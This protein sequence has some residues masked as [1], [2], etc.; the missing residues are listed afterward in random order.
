MTVPSL[1]SEKPWLAHYEKNV[2]PTIR[3]RDMCIPEFLANSVRDFPDRTALNFQGYR[4]TF[5]QLDDMVKRLA[6]FLNT[7]GIKKGDRVAVLLPN[8]IQCVAAYYAILETGAVVVMNNPLYT[9]REL[10]HQFNDSGAKLLITLDL[11]AD[12]MIDLREETD[13]ETIVYTS[14]GDYLPFPKS[15]LFPL[16]AKKKR[17]AATV[18]QAENV[19]IW[20]E[21]IKSHAPARPDVDMNVSDIAMLQYTGGTTGASKG[22]VLT[23]KNIS[24]QIQQAQSWFPGFRKGEHKVLGALPFFHIFGLTVNM[25][26]GVFM[27]WENILVPKPQPENLLETIRKFRPTFAAFVPTM[28]IGMLNSRRISRTDLTCIEGCFSGSAPLPVEIINEFEDKTG[29]VIVEG[30]GLT[31]ASPVT[32]LNPFSKERRKV[33]SVGIPISDTESRI[34]DLNIGKTDV[35][36]GTPGELLVRGP[37]VMKA[38]WNNPGETSAA[39]DDGWLHTGDIAKMDKDGYFYIVDRL[40]DMIISGG[41]NVY[42]REIDEIM[43]EFPKIKEVCAVGIP[44]DTRGEAVKL[45]VVLKKGETATEEEIM[46]YCR[47]NMA[48]YKLPVEIEFR[49]ELPKTTVGKILRRKLKQEEQTN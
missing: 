10:R 12:R 37:Q 4:L 23:H 47:Q 48:R 6:A 35:E 7:R 38:Y 26:F 3:Y 20:K 40:K 32:H 5:L 33:G 18:K 21:I 36:P 16:V 17:L 1:Y 9:D 39:L 11:L 28:I 41:I 30:F 31:E 13:I 49:E 19:F 8:L 34:V 46:S 44:H 42:P 43:Y 15:V 24:A 2:P 22:A 27:G 14:I 45:F 29:A 25:N